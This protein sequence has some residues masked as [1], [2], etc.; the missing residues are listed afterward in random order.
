MLSK[1]LELQVNPM[2]FKNILSFNKSQ[3][4]IKIHEDLQINHVIKYG[5][6]KKGVYGIGMKNVYK[7]K[8]HEC[9]SVRLLA[10]YQSIT[11]AVSLQ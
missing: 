7:F 2:N 4:I 11:N 6:S 10:F 3:Q 5:E 9:H 1:P 8:K